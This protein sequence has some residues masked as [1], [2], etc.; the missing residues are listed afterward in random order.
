MQAPE[1][2][3]A[4]PA[5]RPRSRL[6]ILACAQDRPGPSARQSSCALADRHLCPR[7]FADGHALV[8][9]RARASRKGLVTACDGRRRR[10]A[11]A[12]ARSEARSSRGALAGA[13]AARRPSISA[14]PMAA[15][16]T[17]WVSGPRAGVVA[18]RVAWL[19]ASIR[20]G[21]P[22]SDRPAGELVAVRAHARRS[23]TRRW[24][25]V[26]AISKVPSDAR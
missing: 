16:C 17:S 26:L 21:G 15:P 14:L 25:A 18:P 11:P 20:P 23:S 13:L 24:P 4:A 12:V 22:S 7:P 2:R 8:P 9:S 6:S 10:Y 19:S 5:G 3:R 1:K